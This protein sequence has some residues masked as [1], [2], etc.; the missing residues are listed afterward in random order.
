VIEDKRKTTNVKYIEKGKR[1]RKRK[2]KKKKK[3]K[4]MMD[5]KVKYISLEC[6]LK[7]DREN[8]F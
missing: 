5:E 4:K 6:I 8:L 3:K 7:N 2:K 1:K